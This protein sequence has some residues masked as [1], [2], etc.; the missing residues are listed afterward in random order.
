MNPTDAEL[1]AQL[2]R[3]TGQMLVS[4]RSQHD[5]ELGAAA[6]KDA[7]DRAAQE[8]LSR[9]LAAARPDDAV[10]SEEA[11][12]DQARLGASR[13]WIVDPL[14]GTSDY[15]DGRPEFA[16][17]VAL[18]ENGQLVAAAVAVPA[19]DEVLRTDLPADLPVTPNRQVRIAVSRSRATPL[20]QRVA[21]ALN[22]ELVPLGSAGY[23]VASILFGDVDAYVHSGGQFEWDSAAPVAVAEAAGLFASRLDGSLLRYNQPD[24]Y[25][26]DLIVSRP[27]LAESLLAACSDDDTSPTVP[28]RS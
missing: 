6:L 17:H 14:D 5:P 10:L 1:A 23:K 24:P 19:R 25:L 16:V 26:P 9:A 15:A 11:D 13:V 28:V 7:A 20:M 27:E 12:D 18:W 3:E 4:V 22:A 2:A 8:Y 21:T